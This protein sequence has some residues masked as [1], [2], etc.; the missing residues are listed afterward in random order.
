[1]PG[2]FR[3]TNEEAIMHAPLSGA[4]EAQLRAMRPR[5]M[6]LI[7]DWSD[8]S[9]LS[10]FAPAVK[11]LVISGDLERGRIAAVFGLE[12][13]DSL[14]TVHFASQVKKGY[15]LRRLKSLESAEVVWQPDAA[16]AFAHPSLRSLSIR[17]FPY[18]SLEEAEAVAGTKITHLW[19]AGSKLES[20]TGV[21]R[22]RCLE[23]LRVTDAKRL[24]SLNGLNNP[25][26]RSLDVENA[27]AL[28]D[29]S[30]LR[31]APRINLLRLLSTASG[32]DLGPVHD[33][34]S[35]EVL[36]V[37]GRIASDLDWARIASSP[38]LR[39]VFAWW[40]PERIT[41][42]QIRELAEREGRSIKRFE[43]VPGSGRR[44][45]LVEWG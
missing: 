26:L 35:L 5:R 17:S 15:D 29:L 27:T 24:V 19:F 8:L 13:F 4:A 21:D 12:Q 3:V 31:S 30:A 45:A 1:M 25:A 39:R 32:A 10:E 23:S 20:L 36:Q 44:P 9:V 34:G 22:L 16:S 2:D 11:N 7:G 38:T 42:A 28:A 33:L 37:G 14:T 41:E 18:P 6:Q 40:N 43:P